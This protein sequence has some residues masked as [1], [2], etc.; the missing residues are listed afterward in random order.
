[1]KVLVYDLARLISQ[2]TGEPYCGIEE[3]NAMIVGPEKI[4]LTDD[5][6]CHSVHDKTDTINMCSFM[7]RKKAVISVEKLITKS[8]AVPVDEVELGIFVRTFGA[9]I[10]RNYAIL[11]DSIKEIGLNPADYPRNPK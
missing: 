4:I 2:E 8:Y 5:E 1:M 3:K 11:L 7:T 9:R 6:G 10:E